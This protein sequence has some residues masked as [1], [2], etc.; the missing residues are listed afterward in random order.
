M[1]I[2]LAGYNIDSGLIQKLGTQSAS[3]EVISAA[4]ARISRSQ[5]SVD[6][7]R[8]DALTEVAKARISNEKIIF[9]MGH[10]SVAEHAV[11]NLDLI[12]VSR[13]ITETLQRSR[14]VSFTEKSQRYVTFGRSWVVP[15][16]LRNRA[17]L[18]KAYNELIQALFDEYFLCV[19][20]LSQKYESTHPQLKPRDREGLAKEDARYILPLATKTQMGMTINARNLENLL[21]RLSNSPLS[22]AQEIRTMIL[23]AVSPI[24]PSLVRYTESDDFLGKINI[25]SIG[26]SSFLQQ[27]L[28]WLAELDLKTK[29]RLISST[30]N[31]EDK[32]L[33][34]IIYS[35]GELAWDSNL[36]TVSRLPKIAKEQLWQQIF[37]GMKAWHKCPRAFELAEF[38][39]ELIMSESCWAQ[40][41]RHRMCTLLKKGGDANSMIIPPAIEEI[42]RS[43]AWKD[44]Q[45]KIDVLSD[46]FPEK[47]KHI[48]GYLK[49]NA[50]LCRIYAKMNL[51]EI[52]HFVRLR[53]DSH[54]QWEIREL[55]KDIC[56]AVT[57]QAPNAARL[58]CG[59]SDFKQIY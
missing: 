56:D 27:E 53:S 16:E 39:F 19:S 30:K 21:R 11:F 25:Q 17:K 43:E 6:K 13:L 42:N 12:D 33:A 23:D 4:Y 47:I 28:P 1:K 14:L 20:A 57:G 24:A 36:E 52:Y 54:A 10:A 37:K 2:I 31:L 58:L 35:Q 40:F 22:E 55:S 51:R 5:R 32:I 7:L 45:Q 26:L 3:P 46:A 34:G 48:R 18:K 49:T 9:E 29:L 50:N 41:K 59:K 44:L 38:E 8:Q 15:S